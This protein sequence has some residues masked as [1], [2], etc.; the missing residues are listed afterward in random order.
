[1]DFK[2]EVNKLRREDRLKAQ[3]ILKEQVLSQIH[4]PSIHDFVERLF[5]QEI[6]RSKHAS[7]L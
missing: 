2:E 7:A 5:N 1:M 6:E 4:D 3:L